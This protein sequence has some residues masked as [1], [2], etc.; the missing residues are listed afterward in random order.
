MSPVV[1]DPLAFMD[2][3]DR[4]AREAAA[5]SLAA[6]VSKAHGVRAFPSAVQKLL[7]TTQSKSFSAQEATATIEGDSSLAARIL[8]VVNSPSFAL[9]MRCRKIQTAVTLL[10]PKRLA[11]IAT[12]AAVLDWFSEDSPA[13]GELFKHSSGTAVLARHLAP[14]AG[15]APD[16]L[17]TC[18]LL[19][20]LGKLMMLQAG[21]EAYG[22][23]L[24]L[25]AAHPDLADVEERHRYGFDH[26]TLG[27]IMFAGWNI[28]E[29]VPQVVAW[30]HQPDRAY[31][32]GGTVGKMVATLRWAELLAHSFER[33]DV[34][35][36]A[37]VAHLMKH[38][39]VVHL[40]AANPN[41]ER[42]CRDLQRKWIES[43]ASSL[44][45][46]S[47][48][49]EDDDEARASARADVSIPPPRLASIPPAPVAP[50]IEAP[51]A[52]AVLEDAPSLQP[53]SDEKAPV[54]QRVSK[55]PISLREPSLRPRPIA[56]VELPEEAQSRPR[57]KRPPVPLVPNRSVKP[58]VSAAGLVAGLSMCLAIVFWVA[59]PHLMRV[60]VLLWILAFVS[61]VVG[62][63]RRRT[64]T[65]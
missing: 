41:L 20:D 48:D 11:Q 22:E 65:A 49:D 60:A 19:H 53:V 31:M 50:V 62:L 21:D 54:E 42:L 47:A 64:V 33:G 28:P 44:L 59:S 15:L 1:S 8:R 56:P 6:Y 23:I 9:R 2:E 27:A 52:A 12:A 61:L 46:E 14:R 17:Y 57:T 7:S 30:H 43:Q 55:P 4:P 38:D 13:I 18:G 25:A 63:A 26:A 45:E 32:L 24:G 40:G 36:E 29:P 35:D 39:A 3:S 37:W 34:I 10:G 5:K 58:K 51:I 16:E